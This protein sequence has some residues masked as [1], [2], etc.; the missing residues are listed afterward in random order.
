MREPMVDLV[1]LLGTLVGGDGQIAIPGV[2]EAVAPLT[3]QEKERYSAIDFDVEG[4]RRTAGVDRLMPQHAQD[5][6]MARWRYPSLS[7]HGVEV[8]RRPPL[9]ALAR[10]VARGREGWF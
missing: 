2:M 7:I 10:A 6:L 5:V 3:E 8:G 9:R 4:F 1:A